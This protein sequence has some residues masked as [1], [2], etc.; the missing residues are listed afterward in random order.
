MLLKVLQN[1]I[2]G[3]KMLGFSCYSRCVYKY[4]AENHSDSGKEV[5]VGLLLCFFP[6]EL[7]YSVTRE[8]PSHDPPFSSPVLLVFTPFPR[9]CVCSSGC[10]PPPIKLKHKYVG[11]EVTPIQEV[12]SL[13]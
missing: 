13:W 2:Q 4:D 5:V 8:S 6:W 11:C 7:E 1:M 9:L 10:M 3:I 12:L